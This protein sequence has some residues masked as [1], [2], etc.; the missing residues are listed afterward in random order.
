MEIRWVFGDCLIMNGRNS[1]WLFV[2]R[3][4]QATI[5]QQRSTISEQR[6]TIV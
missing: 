1:C 4:L 5:N 6:S 3:C 2:S